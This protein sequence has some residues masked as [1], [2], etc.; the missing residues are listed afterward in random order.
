MTQKVQHGFVLGK[1]MP[2]HKGHI[3]LLR[4]AAN[5]S[6][7]LTILVCSLPDDPIPG[8]LRYQWVRAMFPNARV[9]HL[10]TPIP[11]EPSEHPDFWNI[12]RTTIK[13]LVPEPIDTVYASESYGWQLATELGATFA[14]VDTKRIAVPTSGT[15]IR[16]NPYQNWDYLPDAVKAHFV[17]RVVVLG[18]ESVGKSTLVQK[19]AVHFKTVGVEEYARPMLDQMVAAGVRAPGEFRYDDLASIARGQIALEDSLAHNANQVMVCD[20]DALTTLTWSDHYFDKHEPWLYQIAQDR[21]YDL[22]LLLVPEG[23]THVQDGTRVMTDGSIRADFTARLMT[24]LKLAGR[25]YQTL[26]GSH[27]QRFAQSVQ[28]IEALFA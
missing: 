4:F 7:Q 18:A 11:Q 6:E 23:T 8:A 9:L 19:L 27:E 22:T 3:H 2:L 5:S 20:T 17:K 25:S 15:T 1:F 16:N 12:W 26:T 14:P 24:N 21:S 10:D 13:C 28:A